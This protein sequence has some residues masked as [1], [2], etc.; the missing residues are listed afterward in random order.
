[1][2]HGS[3]A[4]LGR[5]CDNSLGRVLVW[6]RSMGDVH[7]TICMGWVLISP[8]RPCSYREE[9]TE[10]PSKYFFTVAEILVG[11]SGCTGRQKPWHGP[12]QQA[13]D[14][15]DPG[16]FGWYSF[17]PYLLIEIRSNYFLNQGIVPWSRCTTFYCWTFHTQ[18]YKCIYLPFFMS[19]T[20]KWFHSHFAFV[21]RK[22]P[23]KA[24]DQ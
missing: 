24:Q 13:I 8:N 5:Y 17:R 19:I 21:S 12:Q 16:Y 15:T 4:C 3:R 22:V 18:V 6:N 20:K 14:A 7:R 9:G 10:I 2:L 23:C 11:F 1:M